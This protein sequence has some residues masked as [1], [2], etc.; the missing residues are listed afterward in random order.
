MVVTPRPPLKPGTAS[1]T[2]SPRNG[3]APLPSTPYLREPASVDETGLDINFI[4]DLILNTIERTL[5]E[6]PEL[7]R[8]GR[9]PGTR[10]L[11]VLHTPYIIPYR[12]REDVV[13]ILRIFH[14]ARRWPTQF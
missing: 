11:V 3:S 14:G 6:N 9:V 7:G 2:Q 5:T 10:E 8:P 4:A 12:V 1:L 13:E